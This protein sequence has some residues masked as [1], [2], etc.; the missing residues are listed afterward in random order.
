MNNEMQIREH[1]YRKIEQEYDNFI[2]ELKE[3]TPSEI[4]DRAYEIT[5]KEE[6][7]GYFY[8]DYNYK[9]EEIVA[10]NKLEKPLERLYEDWMDCDR[11]F[12]EELHGS[13]SDTLEMV[14]KEQKLNKK[15][16]ER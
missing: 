16:F 10:L 12:Y 14:V 8:P 5:I 13:I 9:I 4:I 1:L 6:I 7:L 11:N 3:K 15:E 2:S